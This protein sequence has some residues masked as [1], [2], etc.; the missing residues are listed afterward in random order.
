MKG[1]TT[2]GGAATV[3]PPEEIK[4]T[5]TGLDTAAVVLVTTG[6]ACKPHVGAEQTHP[7]LMR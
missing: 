6:C 4:Y 7:S 3:E 1:G 2:G 5:S